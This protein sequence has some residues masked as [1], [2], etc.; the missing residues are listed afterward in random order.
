[1]DISFCPKYRLANISCILFSSGSLEVGV[2]GGGG[3]RRRPLLGSRLLT[4]STSHL[5]VMY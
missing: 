4:L 5:V 1:V 2:D 3:V